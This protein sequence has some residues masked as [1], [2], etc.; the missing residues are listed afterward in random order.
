M[1]VRDFSIHP[2][3]GPREVVYRDQYQEI[4]KV[5]LDF[6]DFAKELFV[7]DYGPRV[8]VIVEGPK[9]ILLTRQYRYL[10]DRISWEIPG[11]KVD[12]GEE[13]EDAARRECLEETGIYCGMLTPLLMFHQGLDTAYNPSHLFCT[14]EY[15]EKIP[16][17]MLNTNEVVGRDW[18]PLEKCI[19]MI[20]NRTIVDS[21]SV[22]AIL[23][24]HV[25][26]N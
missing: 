3:V 11:G 9:G 25:Y 15:E 10:I 17:D 24:Y 21:L 26:G 16:P 14:N 22:I 13:L 18:I 8:G 2:Q 4:Y 5:R 7:T 19:E 23:F 6:G 1:N 12:P 20:A